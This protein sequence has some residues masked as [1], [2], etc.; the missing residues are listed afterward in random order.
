MAAVQKL[1]PIKTAEELAK[2][3]VN[4]SVLVELPEGITGFDGSTTETHVEAP[5]RDAVEQG[6]DV[7][8][9]QLEQLKLANA[10]SDK[11]LQQAQ[12]QTTEERTARIA[13]EAESQRIREREQKSTKEFFGSALEGAKAEGDAAEMELQQANTAGDPAAIAK[14]QRRLAR[15]ESK[16][17]QLEGAQADFDAAPPVMQQT[18]QQ[19]QPPVDFM[20]QVEADPKLLAEEK[21]WLKAH[22]EVIID[23]R[24]NAELGVAY[25]RAVRKGL[26]RGTPAYFKFLNEFME[27]EKPATNGTGDQRQHV[28]T[29]EDTNVAAPVSREISSGSPND[30]RVTLSPE[31]RE[32]AKSMGLTDIQYA[33]GVLRLRVEK[34]ENPEKYNRRA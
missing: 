18:T 23:P 17:V 4:E 12:K 30:R 1:R 5:E 7:L 13:A 27:Y 3:P 22:P 34:Q 32:L 28:Q 19:Q 10:E 31:Q 20:A 25:D 16:L 2:V 6:A 15:A 14:A 33:E 11:R 26:S 24:R 8:T 29:E 21:T 9:K